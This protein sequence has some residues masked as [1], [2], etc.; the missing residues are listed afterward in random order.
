MPDGVVRFKVDGVEVGSPV[1][2]SGGV[3]TL[4]ISTLP[5]GLHSV[6]AE[7]AGSLNFRGITND[8]SPDQLINTPP[9]TGADTIERWPTNGTKVSIATLLANDSDTD[10]DSITLASFTTNSVHGGSLIESNGWLIYRAPEGFTN[11]DSFSYVIRDAWGAV[12]TGLV[13]IVVKE[14]TTPSPN[15][16]ITSGGDGSYHIRFNGVPGRAY[17]I[18]FA[19]QPVSPVWQPLGSAT[20]DDAGAFEFI[21]IPPQNAA[22]RYYRSVYP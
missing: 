18:E 6:R 5:P 21:D 11:N 16:T 14:D 10:G 22:S 17:R 9:V 8:L 13:A 12:S 4:N 20:A 3:A 7:Y 15:L 1:S 2:L 19:E